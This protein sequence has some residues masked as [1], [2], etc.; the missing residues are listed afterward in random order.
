MF[1]FRVQIRAG[2]ILLF[3]ENRFQL[4][5]S[6][7]D[8]DVSFRVHHSVGLRLIFDVSQFLP[9]EL[10][11]RQKKSKSFTPRNS[12]FN[13]SLFLLP[14]IRPVKASGVFRGIPAS[15]NRKVPIIENLPPLSVTAVG[16]GNKENT[17]PQPIIKGTMH[18]ISNKKRQRV[19]DQVTKIDPTDQPRSR[20]DSVKFASAPTSH[21][22][23]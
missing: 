6:I 9:I 18:G 15:S 5:P 14:P 23:V 19:S 12:T 13:S 4:C 20:T 8:L 7:C 3:I 1:N 22:D 11:K 17:V 2:L 10:T 16:A 21:G